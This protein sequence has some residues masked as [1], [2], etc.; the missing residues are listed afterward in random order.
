MNREITCIECPTGCIVKVAVEG[1]RAAE[2]EGYG[3]RRGRDSAVSEVEHPVRMIT[4]TVPSTGLSLR[5]VP[6][7]TSAPV[8]R[9]RVWDVM[10]EI[11]RVRLA[12][13]VGVG[14]VVLA[15]VL[16][17]GVDVIATREACRASVSGPFFPRA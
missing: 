6:V 5:I 15:D 14:D 16:G 1:G 12:Q 13:P 2:V 11:R 4:S 9:E 7:R 3:C 17:L 8:P 10:R